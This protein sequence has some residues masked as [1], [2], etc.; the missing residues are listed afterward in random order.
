MH[1]PVLVTGAS[2]GIGEAIAVYLAQK[3]F[4]VYAAARRM[5]K[6]NA[7][8]GL[9]DGR[10]IPLE[11]DVTDEGS[12]ARALAV[13]SDAGD[14]LYGVV[15]NAGISVFGP[16]EQVPDNEW[17]RQF[18][19]NVFGL[20]NVCRAVIPQMREARAGRI[21]NISSVSGRVSTAFVGPYTATKHAV[22][23]LSDAMRR[24]L[25]PFGVKVSII[26][27]GF[28]HTKFGDQEQESLGLYRGEDAPYERYLKNFMDWH[29][30][31]HPNAKPP[32]LVAEKAYHA[33]TAG[34][35]HSR[36]TVPANN[37]PTIIM[38]NLLPSAI[39]DRLIA[40]ITGLN[41]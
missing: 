29:V 13:I 16:C 3:G 18:E 22:E 5:D 9:S 7:L 41:K 8:S 27:P 11:M 24:E 23:G 4:K 34:R 15:N 1:K 10:I 21:I 40:R 19:T 30:T 28:I 38:R 12:I 35:P 26:R 25:Q 14:G 2:S 39:V 31:Q 6:L 20:M 36:Y 33:L 37:I 32:E 17:R